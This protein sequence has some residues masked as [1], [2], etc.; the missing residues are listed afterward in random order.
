LYARGIFSNYAQKY[1]A[2]GDTRVAQQST[3]RRLVK[4]NFTVDDAMM[5]DFREQMKADHVRVDEEGFAK[6]LDF[7]KAMIRFEIDNALFGV[8]DARRHLIQADPQAV[9]GLTMFG[10]A[11]KL[12]E[13][14]KG[15]R[16][17]AN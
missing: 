16:T 14:S 1:A 7:V 17:K 9:A 6:D 12:T 10:E 2:E 8:S 3:G 13:L 4:P 11:L 15:S 5:A